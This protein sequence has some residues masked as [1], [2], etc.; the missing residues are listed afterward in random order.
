MPGED[1]VKV[2]VFVIYLHSFG[3]TGAISSDDER[4]LCLPD[5]DE[6]VCSESESVGN[7]WVERLIWDWDV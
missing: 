6:E 2:D 4:V 3:E 7:T 5:V 1:I